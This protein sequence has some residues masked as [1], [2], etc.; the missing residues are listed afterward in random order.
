MFNVF[1]VE[2]SVQVYIENTQVVLG[3]CLVPC[4][5]VLPS[6][7]MRTVPAFPLRLDP[8]SWSQIS[9]RIYVNPCALCQ[10]STEIMLGFRS[11]YHRANYAPPFLRP[12]CQL[13][14]AV[15]QSSPSSPHLSLTSPHVLA[16]TIVSTPISCRRSRASCSVRGSRGANRAEYGSNRSSTTRCLSRASSASRAAASG[17]SGSGLVAT[18]AQ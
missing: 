1:S 15:V 16:R 11:H 7:S 4:C 18:P 8:P 2:L 3:Q 14:K 6:T 5:A 13:S 10:T 12:L 9:T 17:S